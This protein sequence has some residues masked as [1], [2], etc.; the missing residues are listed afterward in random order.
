MAN[1]NA[2]L[3]YD[4]LVILGYFAVVLGT[5]YFFSKRMKLTKDFFSAG[6]NMSWW[7]SGISFFMAS[8]S[9]LTF[10]MYAELSYKY[11]IIAILLYQ[12]TVPALII[13]AVWFAGRWRRTRIL[14]PVE[15]L[16]TRYNLFMRQALAWMG[17]PLRILDD[18]L[19][20]FST[21]IFLYAGMKLSIINLPIAIGIIGFIVILYSFMGGQWGV[22]IIDFVQF[23][24]LLIC[25]LLLFPL[26]LIKIGGSEFSVPISDVLFRFSESPY[27]GLNILAFLFLFIVSLNSTWSLV[28]KYNCVSDE[29]EAKK[30]AWFVAFLNFIGPI[31]FFIP[32]ILAR[33][34]LPDLANAK[35]SY[36][37]L[38]LT[39][40][41]TGLM[42]M[43]VA[44]MFSATL[45]TMGS[46]FNVL[47]GI[48]TND[49]YKR[50]FKPSASEKEMII[51]GRAAT[52]IIGIL[53]MV[54]AFLISI[55]QEYNLFDIMIK[56][57]GALLPAT[58]LPILAGL[59]W[60]KINARGALTGLLVGGFSGIMLVVINVILVNQY[61]GQFAQNTELEYWLRQGWDACS[62]FFNS[63]VTLLSLYAGS[64]LSQK[65]PAELE[66]IRKFYEQLNIP[67]SAGDDESQASIRKHNFKVIGT[68][69]GSFGILM[70]LISISIFFFSETPDAFYLNGLVG[71]VMIAI[72]LIFNRKSITK[73]IV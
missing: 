69:I 8:F 20:I 28:Q 3:I 49:L 27:R 47:A 25:V 73:E 18:A 71:I 40:L 31:I 14:T 43:M 45:S 5:S 64:V 46:E 10:V 6:G 24:I 61:S 26:T 63:A 23:I 19:K 37:E 32:A 65:K 11:G 56:A 66:R 44:G 42:G 57:F 22:I 41:P 2:L 67:M 70:L 7:L 1:G 51:V 33:I 35:Y 48:V 13:G 9:A 38:A 68:T 21:A 50:I 30:L 39:V 36:A 29:K 52:I 72:G 62:I 53:I 54:M 55:L 15:F 17:I 59:M 58:A 60:K 12:V 34:L 16:E 4:Y